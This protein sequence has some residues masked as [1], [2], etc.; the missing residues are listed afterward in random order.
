[1]SD[2]PRTE[3]IPR[4][5][6]CKQAIAAGAALAAYPWLQPRAAED[7][8]PCP[9]ITGEVVRWI[10]PTSPGGGYDQYSRLIQPFY[11]RHLQAHV[12]IENIAGAGMIRGSRRIMEAKPDGLTQGILNAGALLMGQLTGDSDAPHPTD[13]FSVLGR[14]SRT[15]QIWA[16]AGDSPLRSLDDVF[17]TARQRPLIFGITEFGANNPV[18]AVVAS[19]ILGIDYELIPGYQG[20]R[21]LTLAA[22]R[23][24]V[25]LAPLTF[26][27]R[28]SSIEAGDL[29][30][31][32]QVSSEP[33]SSHP[34]LEGVPCL[35]GTDGAAARRAPE[36]SRDT[37]TAIADAR[38]LSLLLGAGRLAAAPRGLAPEM[39]ACLEDQFALT[40]SDPECLAAAETANL[41][42]DFAPADEL[43]ADLATAIAGAKRFIPLIDEA[44]RKVR[45]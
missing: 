17:K 36:L 19:N 45:G 42:I 8:G 9:G 23:G 37:E 29:T 10:V 26:A 33:I 30:P 39:A 7:H 5:T 22:I 4:R 27:A 3:P 2:Q 34:V 20:S 13:D 31:I 12:V 11:E 35:G 18:N 25:D 43:R 41:I 1:V 40:L 21:G 38:A 24:E 16:T 15:P 6:F 32:L 28:V 44:K 14:L